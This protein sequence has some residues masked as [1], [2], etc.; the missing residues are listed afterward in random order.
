MPRLQSSSDEGHGSPVALSASG[1][2]DC[3]D[4]CVA[5]LIEEM[6]AR[7]SLMPVHPS[8]ETGYLQ[9]S[10]RTASVCH[11]HPVML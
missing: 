4:A 10:A 2:D 9:L 1:I 6:R 7:F 8:H 11:S 5:G 3:E